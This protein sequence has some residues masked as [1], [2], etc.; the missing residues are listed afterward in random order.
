MA[1]IEKTKDAPRVKNSGSATPLASE[2]AE[3][4]LI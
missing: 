3:S 1:P 2:R 4:H